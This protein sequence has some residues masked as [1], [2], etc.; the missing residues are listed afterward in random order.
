MS[1][2]GPCDLS[3]AHPRNPQ[4]VAEGSRASLAPVAP[5]PEPTPGDDA[6]AKKRPRYTAA[7]KELIEKC[8]KEEGLGY[9]K[10]LKAYPN[11]GFNEHGLRG[12]VDRVKKH[13]S[14]S[15]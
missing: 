12:A 14:L 3:P 4:V 5:A 8:V 13:G 10:I 1:Q 2:P 15:R 9:K 6:P 7:Q 11:W